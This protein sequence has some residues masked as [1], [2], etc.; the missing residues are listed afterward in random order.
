MFRCANYAA[1][2]RFSTAR[3]VCVGGGTQSAWGGR[4][5]GEFGEAAAQYV[6]LDAGEELRGIQAV[7]FSTDVKCC[8]ETGVGFMLVV[9]RAVPRSARRLLTWPARSARF[10]VDAGGG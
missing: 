8:D 5:G 1:V 3:A 10:G 9:E 4:R 2:V 6:V 7:E